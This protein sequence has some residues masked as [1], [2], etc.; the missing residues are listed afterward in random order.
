MVRNIVTAHCGERL[1]PDMVDQ[2]IREI[3]DEMDFGS[4][5][6]AFQEKPIVTAA[7]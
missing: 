1:T 5:A 7:R 4:C 2:I 6:W 3:E